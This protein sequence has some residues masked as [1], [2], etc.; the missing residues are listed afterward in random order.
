MSLPM[1]QEYRSVLQFF[2]DKDLLLDAKQRLQMFEKFVITS[3]E[4]IEDA[5][6]MSNVDMVVRSIFDVFQKLSNDLINKQ[7]DQVVKKTL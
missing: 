1:I 4:Q 2:V 6:T 3:H 5:K 7:F